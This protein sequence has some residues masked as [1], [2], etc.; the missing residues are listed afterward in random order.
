[1][2]CEPREDKNMELQKH[3]LMPTVMLASVTTFTRAAEPVDDLISRIKSAHDTVSGPAWQGAAAYGAKAVK[4]LLALMAAPDFELARR[5]KRALYRIV[6]Y[7]GRP[8]AGKEARNVEIELIAG[9]EAG[10]RGS[11]REVLW[12]LS[13]IGTTRAVGPISAQLTEPELREDARCALTRIPGSKA[14]R[15][16][17][18]AFLKAPEP[19]KYALAESLRVRGEQVEGYPSQKGVPTKQTTVTPVAQKRSKPQ[20]VRGATRGTLLGCF[21]SESGAAPPHSETL[22]RQSRRVTGP[23]AWLV[24]GSKAKKPPRLPPHPGRG[25][26]SQPTQARWHYRS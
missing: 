10:T 7:A 15:A 2:R 8:R 25:G 24:R 6:R 13:E 3:E 16:L 9:L 20:F 19:F 22:A 23:R 14:T 26:A 18:A 21:N 4:P 1:M 17:R 5:A 11:R 12:L